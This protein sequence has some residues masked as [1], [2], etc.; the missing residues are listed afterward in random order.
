MSNI[1]RIKYYKFFFIS[2]VVICKV[3]ISVVIVSRLSGLDP[4]FK[5]CLKLFCLKLPSSVASPAHGCRLYVPMKS[6][7]VHK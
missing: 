4:Q 2:K 7:Y 6:S 5:K 1:T 3:F